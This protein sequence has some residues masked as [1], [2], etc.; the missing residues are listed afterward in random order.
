MNTTQRMALRN[1][2]SMIR[3]AWKATIGRYGF[4]VLLALV[5]IFFAWI[6]F[7]LRDIPLERDEGEYAYV[8]QLM[9]EGI[10][11]YKLAY[12]MKLPGTHAAY[13][14]ILA[15]FGHTP[16]GIHIGLLIVNAATTVLVYL[17]G[18]RLCGRVAGCVAAAAYA[19]L[20]TSFSVMGF[21]AHATHFVVLCVLAGIL[22]LLK[23]LESGR[24]WQFVA[25]GVLLGL[26]VLMKQPGIA[27]AVFCGVYLLAKEWQS[28]ANRKGLLRVGCFFAGILFPF[29]VACAILSAGGVFKAF[30]FWVFDYAREYTSETNFSHGVYN[31]HEG[32][33]K[34][35]PPAIAIWLLAALGLTAFLWHAEMRRHVGL[36]IGMLVSS[37]L[38]VCPGF[39]FRQHYFIL[40]LPV[41]ALLA[42]IAVDCATR[43]LARAGT[44][45]ALTAVPFLLFSAAFCYSVL[46]Q[47]TTLFEQNPI[48]A[49]RE[50]YN[51]NPFPEAVV[52]GQYL[53]RHTSGN[54]RI[55]VLGSEPEIYFYAKRRSATGFIYVYGLTE[56]QRYAIGMQ[57]QM[58]H[59]IET[60]QPRFLV[61]IATPSSWLLEGTAQEQEFMSWA[62]NYLSSRY[63]RVG[64]A[65]IDKNDTQY[66]WDDEAQDYEPRSQNTVQ[67]FK[68]KS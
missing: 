41:V 36:V 25:A 57:E 34:V 18:R 55:A 48:H 21:A 27:F 50:L 56:R 42:G 51:D 47:K 13:A 14:L 23:A 26:A 49:C 43:T 53:N 3:A 10:P 15:L 40:M 67:V 44:G 61:V 8:G 63:E 62:E 7:R 45:L 12:T 64:I 11:P 30:R 1:G 4:Y 65:D 22:L 39:F 28:L 68:R 31:F 66:R 2:A 33:S 20:S 16:A 60:A 9:L 19:L 5:L 59:E 58:I 32:F 52:I 6:R 29:G 38:A 37:C 54:D 17:L 24:V 46:Q 35:V